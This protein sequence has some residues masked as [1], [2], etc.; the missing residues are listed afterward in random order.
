MLLCMW[1]ETIRMESSKVRKPYRRTSHSVFEAVIKDDDRFF[2][3]K[4]VPELLDRLL[5][6]FDRNYKVFIE[7]IWDKWANALTVLLFFKRHFRSP[8]WPRCWIQSMCLRKSKFR[9]HNWQQRIWLHMFVDCVATQPTNTWRIGYGT[10]WKNGII[11]WLLIKPSAPSD[12]NE[13]SNV[14]FECDLPQPIG[15][16]SK[17]FCNLDTIC[18]EIFNLYFFYFIIF[19]RIHIQF[20]LYNFSCHFQ[21]G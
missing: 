18:E 6:S 11:Q 3:T 15:K 1:R 17:L 20:R 16:F 5:K 2:K 19:Y 21:V 9:P 12:V 4:S 14:P 8:I 10:C 7:T 13:C